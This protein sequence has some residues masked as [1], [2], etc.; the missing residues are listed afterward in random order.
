[1][2]EFECPTSMPSFSDY[3]DNFG[4]VEYTLLSLSCLLALCTMVVSVI[5]VRDTLLNVSGKIRHL[6]AIIKL[7]YPVISLYT[8]FS[9]LMPRITFL[10]D[11]FSVVTF[12]FCAVLFVGLTNLYVGGETKLSE[13]S[14][15][16]EAF[17]IRRMPFCLCMC[18]KTSDV[19]K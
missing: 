17:R 14:E 16:D 13:I 3:T 1:M 6:T 19:T 8:I 12:S 4:A 11:G 15:G 10:M 18:L 5:S 9:I 2:E 7:I